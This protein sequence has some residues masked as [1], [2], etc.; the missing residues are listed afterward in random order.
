[1]RNSSAGRAESVSETK[2]LKITASAS[3][4]PVRVF[5]VIRLRLEVATKGK[6]HVYAPGV[7]GY[8]AVSWE[9]EAS[10]AFKVRERFFPEAKRLHLKAIDEVVPVFEGRFAIQAE[11]ALA[12]RKEIEQA[13]TPNQLLPITGKLTYQACD[14][15]TC[16]QPES[17]ALRWELRFDALEEPRVP[18][19]LQH[20]NLNPPPA[21]KD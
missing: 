21:K 10:P 1:M 6:M 3:D 9:I 18:E 17:V 7:T 2:H 15:K 20:K 16:Y 19:A 8:K 12:N 4:D 14:D 5:Q 11:L 13:L